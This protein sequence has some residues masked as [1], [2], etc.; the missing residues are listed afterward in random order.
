MCDKSHFSLYFSEAVTHLRIITTKPFSGPKHSASR[1]KRFKQ[2]TRRVRGSAV[3]PKISGFFPFDFGERKSWE[4]R[5]SYKRELLKF[6]DQNEIPT[7]SFMSRAQA[8]EWLE[9]HCGILPEKAS[10][11]LADKKY[12]ELISLERSFQK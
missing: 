8:R 7:A 4:S 2:P 5:D 1:A 6:F 12:W 9:K 10:V 11:M 3:S